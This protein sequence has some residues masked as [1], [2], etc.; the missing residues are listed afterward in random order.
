[1][2]I[3]YFGLYKIETRN[4]INLQ[5]LRENGLE[6]I[7]CQNREP[8]LKKYFQ[9]LKKYWP[10]RRQCQI[11]FVAFPG[12]VIMPLAW[13]LAKLTGKK[14]VLD[15]FMSAYDSMI[16]DR[17]SYGKYGWAALKYWLLDWFSCAFADI[18]LLDAEEYINYYVKT[19]KIKKSKFRRLLVGSDDKA[20]YPKEQKKQTNNFLVHF[21]GTYLP[22]QG[23]PY[24][25][26]AAKILE[27]A[28][29]EFNIIGQMSTYG[30][31][32]KLVQELNLKNINFIE[33]VP[34]EKLGEYMSM[35]DVCLGM[36]GAT[37]KALRC[38]A[39]KV[40]EAI[41]VARPVITGDTPAMREIFT[42]RENCL[43][44]KMMDEK[45]L[46]VKILELKNNP[47]LREKIAKNGYQTYLKYFTPKAIGAELKSIFEEVARQK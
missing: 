44:S 7:E 14:I 15:A 40:V 31:A 22:L 20:L 32:I 19:F 28:G 4:R 5:A 1:M 9:L 18:I 26:K 21:H 11:I 37:G 47:A 34:Y 46:A 27:P 45:D 3:C 6:V 36:F 12:Y 24:I 33:R 30:E 13:V 8:G 23:I 41:A 2:T 35:A 42:D 16:L 43:Y 38:S 10:I 25:I 17:Q 29:V 39:F